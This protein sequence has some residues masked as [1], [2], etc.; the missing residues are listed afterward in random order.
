MYRVRAHTN[1]NVQIDVEAVKNGA[2]GN[3]DSI[4]IM[5]QTTTN[6]GIDTSGVPAVGERAARACTALVYT[7]RAILAD[8]LGAC[9][10]TLP[11]EL[12]WLLT[13]RQPPT[14]QRRAQQG[15]QNQSTPYKDSPRLTFN[16]S[17]SILSCLV[18]LVSRRT[19]K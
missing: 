5:S 19:M 15:A 2:R 6:G 9:P 7:V 4:S 16:Y 3:F 11:C 8:Q 12:A 13:N 18:M 17:T 10:P 1:C 14:Q